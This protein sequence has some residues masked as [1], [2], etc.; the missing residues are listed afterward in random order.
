MTPV[1]GVNSVPPEFTS[2]RDP[3]NGTVLGSRACADGTGEESHGE[4]SLGLGRVLHPTTRIFTGERRE[5]GLVETDAETRGVWPCAEEA[6]EPPGAGTGGRGVS[7]EPPEHG[8]AGALI[9][10]FRPNRE[11][12]ILCCFKPPLLWHLAA[13]AVGSK[14][15]WQR[16]R[17]RASL[18]WQSGSP[19]T[20]ARPAPT[21]VSHRV[22]PEGPQMRAA[23]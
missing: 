13:A 18:A 17:R 6:R 2:T 9:L 21:S 7:P 19:V 4:T 11:T 20:S 8:A 16:R 12:T 22:R 14:R 1:S 23:W 5:G 10:V 15:A 3:Q